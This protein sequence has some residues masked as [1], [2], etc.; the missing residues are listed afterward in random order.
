LHRK[1][2]LEEDIEVI[3]W[4]QKADYE[5]ELEA[6]I[7][8]EL[9]EA[10]LLEQLETEDLSHI[11]RRILPTR[12]TAPSRRLPHL[13]LFKFA[14]TL[15]FFGLLAFLVKV[16][17]DGAQQQPA[18]PLQVD[19][20]VEK[21]NTKGRKSIIQLSDGTVVTLNAESSIRY[22]RGFDKNNR[23]VSLRGE[24]FFDVAPDPDRPFI[25]HTAQLDVRVLGTRFNVNAYPN[26]PGTRV[27]LAEGSVQ[28]LKTAGAQQAIALVPGQVIDFMTHTQSF[29]APAP[30][31][32]EAEYGW[33]DGILVFEDAGFE[34]A[35]EVLERWYD[36][37]IEVV[38]QP[39]AQWR[40]DS[41]HHN[42]SLELVLTSMSFNEG[43]DFEINQNTVKLYFN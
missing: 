17:I 21:I 5:D 36:V 32:P 14:A 42:E 12:H 41:R 23:Q 13:H 22:E 1:S 8:A 18:A 10:F 6:M 29:G 40:Y 31:D 33:K 7:E 24:A 25:V 30:Y 15:A 4:L 34:E 28:L 39:P 37:Q 20:H 11:R 26:Q 43:F 16:Y 19:H 38:N 27:A 3:G 35:M 9:H 2:A